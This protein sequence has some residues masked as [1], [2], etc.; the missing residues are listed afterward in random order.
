ML[1]R[2]HVAV[3]VIVN[4]KK[5]VLLAL[6]PVEIHQGGLWEFPGGKVEAD[7]TIQKALCRELQEELAITPTDY[8]PLIEI[9]HD[10]ADKSV[11]L[12]VWWVNTF[13][14]EP[15]GCE[16]QPIRW[17]A[18]EELGNYAFPEANQPILHA[19][20]QALLKS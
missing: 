4:D 18:A 7:E 1:K 11:F 2:I 10:Y 16:G 13:D 3:G 15:K 17:V 9:H 6:R 5:E 19:V 12:D 20:Q 14:G 8:H